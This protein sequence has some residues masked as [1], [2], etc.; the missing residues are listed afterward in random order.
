MNS[1]EIGSFIE[2]DLKKGLEYH[3]GNVARLNSGRAAIYH[4][5][6]VLGCDI[7]Y[8][9]YYQCN[10]VRDFLIK[11]KIEVRYY[12]IDKKFNPLI[13]SIP[14][15]SAIVI[16]NYFGIMSYERMRKLATPYENVIIDNSQ[17]FFSKPVE[18]CMNVYSARKFIG[19]PD[20]AYVVGNKALQYIS[21][22]EQDY[23]SDT[24][25]F[26]LQRIEYG[27]EGKTYEA[28]MINENRIN[29]SDVKQMSKLTHAILDG[30]DYDYVKQKR[31]E[32]YYSICNLL[33][34]FNRI[35]P[36]IYYDETCIPMVYPLIVEDDQL[37]SRL[38]KN[39]MF[40]GHW[41]SYLLD[42][43][44]DNTFEYWLS[45]FVIPIS[46]DQR[47]GVQELNYQYEIIKKNILL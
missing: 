21:D 40:Q 7:V 13:N 6:R 29:N 10:T 9:P 27:C 4:S 14:S 24:S 42:E 36:C 16:V 32:N 38:L 44:D 47:Y 8:L 26:L 5:A 19:V 20:G 25:L 45:R 33:N 12:N 37:L 30:T 18:N 43:V 31:S 35:D 41:W 2:L 28:R 22:Y 11:K 17:A 34:K 39:K 3:K 15:N 23:S 1:L 46:I